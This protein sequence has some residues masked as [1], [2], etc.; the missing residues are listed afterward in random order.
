[1]GRLLLY[2]MMENFIAYMTSGQIKKGVRII[3]LNETLYMEMRLLQQFCQKFQ[4]SA[5]NANSIPT[6][7][8]YLNSLYGDVTSEVAVNFAISRLLPDRLESQYC[9]LSNRAISCLEQIAV[10]KIDTLPLDWLKM[11]FLWYSQKGK[12]RCG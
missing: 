12:S 5:K 10:M 4:C 8:A 11:F 2:V 6:I 1:M 3:T 9:F 7:M